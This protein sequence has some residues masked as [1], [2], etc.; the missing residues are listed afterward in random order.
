MESSKNTDICYIPVSYKSNPAWISLS[1][2]LLITSS[3]L[4]QGRH[5]IS[6]SFN[7][8]QHS[9]PRAQEEAQGCIR[10]SS[11]Y[12]CQ[13]IKSWA[14]GSMLSYQQTVPYP[15]L[16]S[17]PLDQEFQALFESILMNS[18]PYIL[19]RP[20]QLLYEYSSFS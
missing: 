18:C 13:H 3:A 7:V 14:M 15:D 8:G 6:I 1:L 11:R 16:N 5:D 17:V 2:S 19:S 10:L 12:S 9:F 4:Y 20:L